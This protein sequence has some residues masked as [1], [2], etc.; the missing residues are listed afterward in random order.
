MTAQSLRR[1]R[2]KAGNAHAAANHPEPNHIR[3]CEDRDHPFFRRHH[4]LRQAADVRVLEYRCAVAHIGDRRQVV[5]ADCTEELAHVGAASQASIARPA[6]R[7]ARDAYPIA[8]ANAAHLRAHC[9]DGPDSTV[10]LD[11]RH[12][13]HASRT[14]RRRQSRNRRSGPDGIWL[15]P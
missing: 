13:I 2:P 7:C 12:V 8:D 1:R 10:S 15:N 11:H 9:F 6:L 4:Q 5:R 3:F 14:R